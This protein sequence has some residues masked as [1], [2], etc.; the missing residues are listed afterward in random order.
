MTMF[1]SS[2]YPSSRRPWRK[3][4]MRGAITDGEVAIRYPIRGTFFGCCASADEE[5]VSRR[6]VSNQKKQFLLIVFLPAFFLETDNWPLSTVKCACESLPRS[7]NHKDWG[8]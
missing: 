7:N 6:L 5:L 8:R 4:S 2:M 3:A 1:F